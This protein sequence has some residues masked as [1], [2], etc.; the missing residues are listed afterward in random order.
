MT[1]KLTVA[2]ASK[3]RDFLPG[4]A[5]PASALPWLDQ[6]IIFPISRTA[7]HATKIHLAPRSTIA[8]ATFGRIVFRNPK[9]PISQPAL[10]ARVARPRPTSNAVERGNRRHREMQKTI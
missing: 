2:R 3:C 8:A 9:N 5:W 7:S 6:E 1:W 4:N 10:L